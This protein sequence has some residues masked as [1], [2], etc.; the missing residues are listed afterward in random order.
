MWEALHLWV[1]EWLS[2]LSSERLRQQVRSSFPNFVPF[3]LFPQSEEFVEQDEFEQSSSILWM[4]LEHKQTSL[5]DHRWHPY[6]YITEHPTTL[7]SQHLRKHFKEGLVSDASIIF[8][9]E[10]L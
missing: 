8:N 5:L 2:S 7:S 6:S 1:K 4:Q 10:Y 3:Q 9:R